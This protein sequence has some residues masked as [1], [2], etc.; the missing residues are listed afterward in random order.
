MGLRLFLLLIIVMAIA[1]T[2]V[3]ILNSDIVRFHLTP[4]RTV[5]IALAELTLIA[6]ALGAGIVLLGTFVKDA[7]TSTKMW[8]EK[9][10]LAKK[11]SATKKLS[12][13]WNLLYQGKTSAALETVDSILAVIPESRSAILLKAMIYRELGDYIEEVKALTE[14][15]TNDPS[16]VDAYFMLAEALERSGDTDSAIEVLTPLKKQEDYRKIIEKLRD[17]YIKKGDYEKAHELQRAI[18]KKKGDVK[19]EDRDIS[20]GLKFELARYA[21]ETGNIDEAEKKLKDLLKESPTFTP[22]YILLQDLYLEKTQANAAMD[23]LI[24]GYRKT[25]NP[26][27]LIKLE[28]IAIEQEMPGR[29]LEIYSNVKSE[30]ENDF[31]LI[32]FYGKFLLRLEMVDEAMEQFLKAQNIEPDNASIHIFLAETYRRR[33]RFEDAVNEYNKAFAYKRRYLVPFACDGCGDTIIRWKSYCSA[34]QKWDIFR[35]DY[36]D[37]KKIEEIREE[38]MQKVPLPD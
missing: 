26:I 7:M 6:F 25:K 30:F 22:S 3:S 29:L 37:T 9:R 21:F 33:N 34:C 28:D 11:E 17:L 38:A 2:H 32:L 4:G 35:I 19:S 36:G 16:N 1:F 10:L 20:D 14:I 15:K 24:S 27:N 5:E 23:L 8:R 12:K 13:A 18:I 31:T